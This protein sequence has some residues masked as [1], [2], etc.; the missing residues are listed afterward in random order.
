M[1]IFLRAVHWTAHFHVMPRRAGTEKVA[2]QLIYSLCNELHWLYLSNWA[3][4]GWMWLNY[5]VHMAWT[6]RMNSVSIQSLSYAMI[7]TQIAEM[8]FT[9]VLAT[10]T[11]MWIRLKPTSKCWF[12]LR[13]VDRFI[14]SCQYDISDLIWDYVSHC[15]ESRVGS[16]VTT[17][18]Q[19]H[20]WRKC[21]RW[22]D[23]ADGGLWVSV[24][25][26][27]RKDMM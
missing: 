6:S 21:P 15:M 4:I 7:L 26:E 8:S 16:V 2:M 19:D 24:H 11:D 13:G 17:V 3:T 22:D 12:E 27:S 9:C 10:S 5:G 23:G 14:L 25:A 1:G 18:R 20:Y